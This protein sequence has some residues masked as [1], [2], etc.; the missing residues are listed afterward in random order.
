MAKIKLE[1]VLVN[2]PSEI[3]KD[4]NKTFAGL[5]RT[6][7]KDDG[8]AVA[9]AAQRIQSSIAPGKDA[10]N[11]IYALASDWSTIPFL[12]GMIHRME[13]DENKALIALGFTDE[14]TRQF[15]LM[16]DS[17]YHKLCDKSTV[18]GTQERNT[19]TKT[20]YDNIAANHL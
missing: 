14:E 12:I 2:A 4:D 19:I 13:T 5:W 20:I 3:K 11:Q 16:Y 7:F 8:L 18:N 17:L 1:S 6:Y 10:F 15:R 9:R